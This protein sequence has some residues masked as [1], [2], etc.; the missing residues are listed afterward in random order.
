MSMKTPICDFVRRY[1]ESN[2]LR[3]H[4][5]GHKGRSCLGFEALDITEIQGADSLYEASGIIAESEANASR[6]FGCATH[7]STEGASQCI[8]AMLQLAML[9]N[10]NKAR[11]VLAGRNAHKAFLSAAALLDVDVAWL[12]PAAE[13]SYLSCA[14]TPTALEERL[15][16]ER[17]AAVYLTSPDYLGN[18]VDIR[19]VA[20]VCHRYGALL[21]VD[22]AHGAYLKFLPTSQHPIDLGADMCCDS[23]HKTLPV[24]TGGAYLHLADTVALTAAQVKAALA[25][26]G[27]T[28]P[29]Y[30]I[31]Q[32]LDAANARLEDYAARLAAFLPRVEAMK[33]RL[34]TGGYSLCGNE[35]L[36]ITLGTKLYGYRGDE[37]ADALRKAG[38]ECEFSDPDYTVLML[39]PLLEEDALLRAEDV[40]LS[41]PQKSPITAH[42][43]LFLA[44]EAVF[45]VREAMLADAEFVSVEQACGRVLAAPTVGCPPAVPIAICGERLDEHALAC[46]RYYSI[47][48]CAVVA[49]RKL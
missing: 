13:E 26:F 22:N 49:D 31:L 46:F 30:L 6:L 33:R 15:S 42:P 24:L 14:V 16:R 43:P 8:R 23:A 20:A 34:A 17:V 12:Y 39:T 28:S 1:A 29:S 4:M 41:L 10:G 45:T 2:T 19:G 7:Y 35:P 25:L 27:S 18:T 21:L 48:T 44:G 3:L 32:S 5:P 38:V 36:K 9:C 40:L 11:R 47:T 37:V